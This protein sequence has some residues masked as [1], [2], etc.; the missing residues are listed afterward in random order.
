MEPESTSL[1][2]WM[3][4]MLSQSFSTWS[5]RWVEKRTALPSRA[6]LEE[7]VHEHHGVDGVEAAKGLVHDD[8]VG[9]VEQGWR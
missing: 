9:I 8:E 2:R 7:R 1:P 3:R 6:Q 5:M 4:A